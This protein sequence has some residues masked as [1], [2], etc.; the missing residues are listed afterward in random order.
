VIGVIGGTGFLGT[1]VAHA[2]AIRGERVRVLARNAVKTRTR[3]GT[4]VDATANIEVVGGDMHD[5]EALDRLLTGARTAYVL[6]QT[7]TGRQAAGTGDFVQAERAGL[8]AIVESS[9]RQGVGRLLTVG[10]IGATSDARNA[11]V[12]ARAHNDQ[13]L[14]S[15]GLDVTIPRGGLIAGIGSVGFDA[16]L[17]AAGKDVAAIAP[18]VSAGPTSP[19]RTSSDIWL[20]RWTSH[21]PTGG[22]STSAA[23]RRRPTAS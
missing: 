2:V 16:V 13:Y 7:V 18:G 14:L 4:C 22:P 11:W 5:A 15:S 12:R 3:S 17:A 10:L 20:P 8:A 21:V 1:P 9:R 23:P 19:W 6:V